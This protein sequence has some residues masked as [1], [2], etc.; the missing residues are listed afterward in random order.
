MFEIKIFH[1]KLDGSIGHITH[2]W[3]AK[4]PNEL[5]KKW[6]MHLDKYEGCYYEVSDNN[7]L[8][9]DWVYDPD[10]YL[11]IGEW[12]GFTDEQIEEI[13]NK[14]IGLTRYGRR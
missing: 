4:I 11:T 1:E 13:Y 2:K 9:T 8:I 6:F 14:Y 3:K 10:D 7:D 12:L 5:L